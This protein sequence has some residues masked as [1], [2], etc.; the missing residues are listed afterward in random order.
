MSRTLSLMRILHIFTHTHTGF[1]RDSREILMRFTQNAVVANHDGPAA[2]AVTC[3]SAG[4]AELSG[5]GRTR[6]SLTRPRS[7]SGS[8]ALPPCGLETARKRVLASAGEL[9]FVIENFSSHTTT[10]SILREYGK[11][12]FRRS[13]V[14]TM[15]HNIRSVPTRMFAEAETRRRTRTA[16]HNQMSISIRCGGAIHICT[17]SHGSRTALHI[18]SHGE[19]RPCSVLLQWS[20]SSAAF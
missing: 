7:P 3:S 10:R 9:S 19:S 8:T 2:L 11:D 12:S 13:Y 6:T 16:D 20:A 4:V 1:T 14:S 5:R 17:A 15:V 18:P